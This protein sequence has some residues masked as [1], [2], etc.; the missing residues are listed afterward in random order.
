MIERLLGEGLV[1]RKVGIV[2]MEVLVKLGG[3]MRRDESF[4]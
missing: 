1:S 3:A 2:V 4:C